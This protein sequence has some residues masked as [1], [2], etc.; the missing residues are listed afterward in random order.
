MSLWTAISA[1]RVRIGIAMGEVIIADSTVTGSGVVLAQR[2]EQLAEADGVNITGAV[3]EALPTRL[4]LEREL[5]G[6]RQLRGFDEPVTVYSVRPKPG[7]SLPA[8]ESAVR[9]R[10]QSGTGGRLTGSPLARSCS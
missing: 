7:A 1:P 5:L 3:N 9:G 8:P 10:A 4:P 6:A 2:V